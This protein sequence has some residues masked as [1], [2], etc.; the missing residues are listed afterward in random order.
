[1]TPHL[2]PAQTDYLIDEIRKA[3][4]LRDKLWCACLVD[5]LHLDEVAEVLV[6]FNERKDDQ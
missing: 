5:A 4:Q 3:M 1:M 6:L 2:S